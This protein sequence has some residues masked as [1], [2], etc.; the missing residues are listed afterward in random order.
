VLAQG[1]RWIR[2]D[3]VWDL[4][5]VE[6]D[7]YVFSAGT[8]DEIVLSHDL[9]LVRYAHLGSVFEFTPVPRIPWPL[10]AGLS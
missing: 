4:I 2:S 6:S 10:R 7:R 3:G 9:A 1:E 8:R 5:R